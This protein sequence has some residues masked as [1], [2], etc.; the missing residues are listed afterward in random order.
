MDGDVRLVDLD[1]LNAKRW[2]LVIFAQTV[3][4]GVASGHALGQRRLRHGVQGVA[5]ELGCSLCQIGKRL[6][7]RA[8]RFINLIK[9]VTVSL[10]TK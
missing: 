5:V 4:Q 6:H 7:D 3:H 2:F 8:L 1:G 10:A 9:H